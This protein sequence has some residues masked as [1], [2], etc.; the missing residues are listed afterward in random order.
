MPANSCAP[1]STSSVAGKASI[2]TGLSPRARLLGT[3]L[4]SLLLLTLDQLSALLVLQPIALGIAWRYG[5][6]PL[7]RQLQRLLLLDS[8]VLLAIAPIPFQLP[9]TPLLQ[10]GSLIVT[11]NGCA[12]ALL[13]A[14]RLNGLM[15]LIQALLV[16]LEPA[17]LGSALR[18][19]H[20][21][22]KL[23]ALL[24]LS[25]QQIALLQRL[26]QQQGRAMR[27]RGWRARNHW[28]S[29]RTQAWGGAMLLL[30]SL[31]LA[32]RQQR[33]MRARGF[34]GH[35]PQLDPVRWYPQDAK[36][37]VTLLLGSTLLGGLQYGL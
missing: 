31:E 14:L 7:K 27:A 34:R 25:L 15:L 22:E 12:L 21:P 16:G 33:A 13:L 36:F 29:W 18:Y 8:L 5:L 32:D 10:I 11:D 37:A 17:Q 3:L 24:Q 2:P 6:T 19:L 20:T 35:W 4:L 28:R 1:V 9:G 30:R 23:I 26:Q